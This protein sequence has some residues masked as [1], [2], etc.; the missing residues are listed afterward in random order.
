MDRVFVGVATA[1]LLGLVLTTSLAARDPTPEEETRARM[2]TLM[3]AT[4]HYDRLGSA[5][6]M[7]KEM[8][9]LMRQYRERARPGCATGE[10][11]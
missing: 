3:D 4:H 2:T 10:R 8:G 5:M 7:V 1:L 9:G 11:R 6:G